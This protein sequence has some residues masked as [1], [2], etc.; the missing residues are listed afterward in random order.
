MSYRSSMQRVVARLSSLVRRPHAWLLI[1][2]LLAVL[3]DAAYAACGTMNVPDPFTTPSTSPMASG[4]SITID[5]SRCDAFGLNPYPGPGTTN[6]SHGSVSVDTAAGRITYTNNGDGAGSDSFV[7]VDASA[8]PFTVNVAIGLA[9]SPITVSPA[10]LPTPNVGV[11]YSQTLSASGGTAPYTYNVTSGALAPGLSLAG[12]TISGTP[13][14]AGSSTATLTVTDGASVSTTK[15]YAVT[16]PNPSSGITVAAPTVANLNTPYS[17]DLNANTSGALAPYSYS[18]NSGSLPAGL[19]LSGGVISGTPTGTGTSNFALVVTDSSPNLGGISP[20]PYFKV[21]NLSLTVQ[22]VPPTAGAVSA[23]VTYG[24]TS[25]PITLNITGAPATSVAIGTAPAHGS[26]TASGTSITY[27]PTVGYAGPDSFTYTATNGAGT[28]APATVTITVLT[29]TVAIAPVSVPAASIGTAYAQ[30]LSAS[31]G[32]AP[33]T[34]SVTAGALPPGVTLASNGT[35]SGTPTASGNFNFTLTATDSSTG[36]GPFTGSR[37]YSLTVNAPTMSVSPA[38]LTAGTI[39]SA[40]GATI[41]ASGGTSPYTFALTSG[42]LPAGLTLTSAGVLSG[43]PTVMGTFNFTVTATD[44]S[45]GTG[46]FTASRAYTLVINGPTITISPATLS[47][48]AIAT[49]YATTTLSASGGTA[50]YAFAVTAGAL[51]AGLSLSATGDLSGVPTAAGTF[52]FTVTATDSSTGSGAPFTGS[53]AYSL[54]IDGATITVSP[55]TLPNGTIGNAYTATTLSAAGGTAPY[56]FSISAGAL[57]AGLS[58]GASGSLSGTPTVSGIFNFTVSATDSSTGTG[59]PFAGS[60]AYTLVIDAVTITIAPASVPGATAGS[61]YA[62]IAL[63]ASGGTAPYGF[64]VTAGALP[65][66][67]SLTPSGDLSGTPTSAGTFNFTITAT[68]SFGST[69]SQAYAVLVSAVVPDAPA[70]TGVSAGD[71]QAQITVSAPLFDGGAPITGYTAT[72]SPGGAIGT[73]AG[74]AGGT[75]TVAG[76]SNGTA[77]TFTVVATNAA[78]ISPPS[79]PSASVTPKGTQTITFNNPGTQNFGT[80]PTLTATA[81]SGLTTTFSSTTTSVCTVTS[82]G[83]LTFVTAG[84]CT[85]DAD[86]GGNTAYL[87]A[88]TVSQSFTIA[89][90]VPGAP[91]APNAT[92]GDASAVVSFVAPLFTG[93]AAI[94]G[95]TVTSS[96]G[97]ISATGAGSGITVTGLTNG[98]AYTFSVT[99]NNSAGTGSASASSNSVTPMGAQTITFNNPGAQNFGTS[100]TLTATASS[101]LAVSFSSATTAVCTITGG[102][103]LTLLSPGTCTINA[104]QA[105]NA[106]YAAAAQVTQSFAIV[107]PGGAVSISTTSLPQGTGGVAYSQSITAAGGATP[108][109][110]AVTAGALP[111]GVSMSSAGV[112]SGTPTAAGT[113]NFTVQVTDA[114]TQTATQ[115]LTLVIA[116][117]TI[118]LSPAS[119]PNGLA[120]TAYAQVISAAGGSGPYTFALTSGALPAGMT[121]ASDGT[122]SGTPTVSGAFNI[123]ITATDALGFTGAQAYTLNISAPTITLTP[124]TLPGATVA[125]AYSQVLTA[126]GGTA[127]YTVALTAGALPTGLSLA[128]DGTLSGTPT[129]GGSFN[130]S[131]TATDALGFTGTQAYVLTVAAPGIALLPATLPGA[132]AGS[133]YTQAITA[134]G[135]VAPYSFAITAG[136]LPGGLTLASDGTLSGTPTASGSFNLSITATDSSTGGGPYSATQAYTLVVT[137]AP[138]LVAPDKATTL[139]GV[140]VAIAVTANDTG[141]IDSIA[142]AS[143]PRHGTATV[144]GLVVNYTSRAGFSGTDRFTYVA[145]GPGG[146]SSPATVTVTVH[147]MPVAKSQSVDAM[148]AVPVTVNLTAGAT[149][150]P[151]TAATLVA[152][153]PAN[154]GTATIAHEGA[155]WVMHFTSDARFSGDAKARF[156]L[157]NAYATSAEAIIT[158]QV[159]ARPDPSQDAQVRGLLDAQVESARRFAQAQLGN[160]HQRLEQLHGA[161]QRARFSSSLTFAEHPCAQATDHA[162]YQACTDR[163][164]LAQVQARND[165]FGGPSDAE[166]DVQDTAPAATDGAATATSGAWVGGMLRSGSFDGR[167]GSGIG[168]ESDGISAGVDTDLSPAFTLG[169]GLGYGRDDNTIDGGSRLKGSARAFVGYASYHPWTH[170]FVDGTLGFQQLDYDSTRQLTG[171]DGVVRGRRDGDQ[172]F[173]SLSVGADLEHGAWQF[174]PYARVDVARGSLDGFT[175]TGHPYLALHYEAMDLDSTTGNLGLRLEFRN[176]MAWGWL[177]PQLRVEYQREFADAQA[178][179]VRYADLVN[180]PFY[181][182]SPSGFDRNRFMLGLGATF[183]S[184][185]GWS[186][187]VEYQTQT[188]GQRDEGVQLNVQKAF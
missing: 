11:A 12:S 75:I 162:E 164:A 91:T 54:V 6:P 114:A 4:G 90:V 69:G 55:G 159:K 62:P 138:P 157:D 24:S 88:P 118:T 44:A 115:P 120:G 174:T 5:A 59:A 184:N 125:V 175:E 15:S 19:T 149:G 161:G 2:A 113:F 111:P 47:N 135:G 83:A 78:G 103:A 14:Q 51:P 97:G 49:A 168:F 93:G 144:D 77:Y 61:A 186:T 50:P 116:A 121:L 82:G 95:Y 84:T 89:A 70:I 96:P 155:T 94:T 109:S 18:L 156:T 106:A 46:P 124:A 8:I 170:L 152:L 147:P 13:N 53:R 56:T 67:L 179:L 171:V 183:D 33:Y 58:L 48:G 63:T 122:L 71:G 163:R 27:T 65:T 112:V 80:A 39:N 150:G 146:T 133:A 154:A 137:A 139:S 172:W 117:P 188:G 37:A 1:V 128:T 36:T 35:L 145:T 26:A 7:V 66:G 181:T 131:L 136:A 129:A 173:G 143:A 52:N 104:N 34:Y 9:S 165:G 86:Q 87:A 72:A 151:F 79:A 134:T 92:A 17:Y 178:A 60:Q 3:P 140:A 169:A 180:G 142:V 176:R 132:T 108:Y 74:A 64:A 25:N 160:F 105:G 20:G 85:I 166:A 107:V 81:S 177:A 187:H 41:S 119:L 123:T 167:G 30:S 10:S 21:V 57:P 42:A 101:G 68:D 28:S 130:I 31:G 153:E 98:T 76:L 110:F 38:S 32:A 148:T 99:A 100:P 29:P 102:G 73:L 158:F 43:T 45:T 182:L 22:N 126:N 16:V 141:R 23:S 185:G 40:Y 127:P